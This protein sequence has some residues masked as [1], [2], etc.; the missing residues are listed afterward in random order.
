MNVGDKA[1]VTV[2]WREPELKQ[3]L[4]LVTVM[5]REPELKQALALPLGRIFS[6]Q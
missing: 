2:M 3:V 6:V 1:L 5:W 4:A